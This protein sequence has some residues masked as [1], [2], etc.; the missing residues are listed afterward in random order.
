MEGPAPVAH[1]RAFDVLFDWLCARGPPP[2]GTAK[3]Y[4]YKL[5]PGGAPCQS[6]SEARRSPICKHS[7]IRLMAL[8]GETQ[9]WLREKWI[10]GLEF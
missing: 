8:R 5:N 2:R 3:H 6:E 10:I 1:G 4:L 9:D 7:N